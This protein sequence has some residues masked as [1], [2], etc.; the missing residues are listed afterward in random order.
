VAERPIVVLVAGDPV[1]ETRVSRGSFV[2]LIRAAAATFSKAPWLAR[3]VRELDIIPDLSDAMA[4]IVTGSAS[5]VTEA[6]PWME[7]SAVLLR[8]LIVL[9]VPLLGIC[10]G[11]QLL[12][13]ALGGRVGMNPRGREMGTVELVIDSADPVLGKPGAVCVNSTHVDSVLQLPA[14][15]RVLGSTK[16]EPHAAVRF[17][18]QAWGV[19]FHPEIDAQVMLQYVDARAPVLLAEGFDT[20]AM[21]HAVRDTPSG[22]AIIKRFLAGAHSRAAG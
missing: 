7:R 4:V 2:E 16:L 10:F 20:G 22:P 12:G 5:S 6:L 19:Q 8:Q 3:D 1:L 11:H 21:R 15:A 18:P 13:H 14:G 9:E 17:G